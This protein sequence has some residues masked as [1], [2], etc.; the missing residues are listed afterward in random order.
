MSTFHG[1][2]TKQ[3][4]IVCYNTDRVT[5]K[6][7]KASDEGSTISLFKLM[8]TGTVEN[9]SQDMIHVKRFLMVHWNNAVQFIGIEKRLLGS[10]SVMFVFSKMIFDTEIC[11]D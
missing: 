10:N 7:S 1:A 11:N 6:L 4:T 8:E 5:V 2:F 3:N 9:T